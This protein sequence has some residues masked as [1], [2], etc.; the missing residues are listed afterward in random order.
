MK[1]T[2]VDL[3]AFTIEGIGD[4]GDYHNQKQG[5][6]IVDTDIA[7]PMSGY[8]EYKK[9]R[10]SWGINVLGSIVVEIEYADGTVGVST[11]FGGQPA[12]YFIEEHFKRFLI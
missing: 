5:H 1:N 3:R 2:I 7:N 8:D 9:S 10:T 12:C 11:G 6:W 4:G